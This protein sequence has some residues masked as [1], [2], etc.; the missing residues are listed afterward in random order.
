MQVFCADLFTGERGSG[1]SGMFMS[2]PVRLLSECFL[3][4]AGL[5]AKLS[6]LF[7]RSLKTRWKSFQLSVLRIIVVIVRGDLSQSYF[8]WSEE[9]IL[10]NIWKMTA[11]IEKK[12]NPGSCFPCSQT[13]SCSCAWDSKL[14]KLFSLTLNSH[15]DRY[16]ITTAPKVSALH[17]QK[18]D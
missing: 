15:T 4:F 11:E 7:L 13:A 10:A 6:K 14:S 1:F 9:R 8:G 16:H 5:C 18:D 12:S 3:F 2:V 17:F